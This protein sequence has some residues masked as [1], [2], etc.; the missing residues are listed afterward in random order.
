MSSSE[1]IR[2]VVLG[3]GFGGIS[4]C[5]ELVHEKFAVT[6][7]D[8]QNHHLFQPLLY[9]VATAGL[10]ATDIAQPI[11]GILED[12][13]NV[14]VVMDQVEE[15]DLQ[16]KVVQATLAAYPFDY[17]VI[18]LGAVTGYFGNNQWARFAPG[19]K[20]LDDARKIRRELLLAFERAEVC[21][22]ETERNRLM[23]IVVVG[24][25]PTGVEMAGAISELARKVLE[26]SFRHIDPAEA[27]VVLV[28]AIPK[29]LAMFPED[30]QDYTVAHLQEMGVEVRLSSPVKDVTAEGVVIGDDESIPAANVIWAAGVDA[31]PITKTIG[32][33][34]DRKG[35][36]EV[37]KDL[38]VP[39]YP[40]VFAIGDIAHCVDVNGVDVPGVSP[41][42]LQMGRHV[43]RV[44]REEAK[45]GHAPGT[46]K[47]RA[48]FSYLNKGEMATIG[49]SAAVAK[50][51]KIKMKGFLAWLGWLF[52]HLLFLVGFRNKVSVFMNWLW[53][54]ITFTRGARIITGMDGR[55]PKREHP[56]PAPAEAPEAG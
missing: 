1:K 40:H 7:I 56:K 29:V 39:G 20:S 25:G 50:A 22:D 51:G 2:V 48:G 6:L 36:I 18:G 4:F 16:N 35:R 14:T 12:R 53:A 46:G 13:K 37:Q 24:G 42:A 32:I 49:R 47:G 33:E 41:A 27:R 55:Q 9:Q 11:R 15:I 8:R 26:G 38:S 28:E 21:A 19:L 23:T 43:A 31:N 54:Y 17:L 52:V 34:I 45:Y 5:K 30:L 3:A 44:I 10:A